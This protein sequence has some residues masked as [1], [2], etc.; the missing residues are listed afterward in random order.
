MGG[1]GSDHTGN[2]FMVL[3]GDGA[4]YAMSLNMDPKTLRNLAHRSDGELTPEF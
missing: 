1:I 3:K 4:V 2:L